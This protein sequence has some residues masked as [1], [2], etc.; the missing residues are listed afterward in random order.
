MGARA[1]CVQGTLLALPERACSR[2]H[3]SRRGDRGT[4][5]GTSVGC[6]PSRVVP[7]SDTRTPYAEK[8]GTVMYETDPSDRFEAA[9]RLSE[10]DPIRGADALDHV[11]VSN[12]NDP[13]ERFSGGATTLRSRP[14]PGR[15][16]VAQQGGA[17]R[18][19]ASHRVRLALIRQSGSRHERALRWAGASWGE[20]VHREGAYFRGGPELATTS[21]HPRSC[22]ATVSRR[23]IPDLVTEAA[24]DG[25]PNG[26]PLGLNRDADQRLSSWLA[27]VRSRLIRSLD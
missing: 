8:A 7:C 19:T 16:E 6:R 2:P 10:E 27:G 5:A 13:D 21:P 17:D 25:G 9:L 26:S 24:G 12:E 22:T 23:A 4:L 11:V 1:V 3:L 14:C 20:A 18:R 15:R